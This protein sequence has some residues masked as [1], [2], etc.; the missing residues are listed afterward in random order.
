M[1]EA[2]RKLLEAVKG[3]DSPTV[4]GLLDS[5]PGLLKAQTDEGL[6]AILLAVYHRQPDIA[7]AFVAR[8]AILNI[9]ES[10]ALG[11]LDRVRAIVAADE[12]ATHSFAPDG[13]TPLGLACF[14][15]HGDVV[16]FLVREGADVN[17][18]SKNAQRVA[19]LH[20]AAAR[21]DVEIVGALLEAGADPNRR[22][23]GGVTPL[24]EAAASGNEAMARLLLA[25]GAEREARTDDGRT[26]ADLAVS[27][28]HEALA[29]WLEGAHPE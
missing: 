11:R 21:N 14:F 10:C 25:H 17:L 4:K 3:G 6:S 15:G 26:P 28:K 12:A 20:A 8:G 16:S 9:F 18:H 23:E 13:H 27:R 1:T 2:E 7:Q 5:S 22:Q 29:T 19:P 24:H